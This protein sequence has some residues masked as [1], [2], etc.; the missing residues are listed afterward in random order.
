MRKFSKLTIGRAITILRSGGIGV[1]PTDTIYGII[2][3]ALDKKAV[4]RIYRLRHRHPKKPMIVLIGKVDDL[5]LFG[6]T[7]NTKLVGALE[8][9]WPGKF[10]VVFRIPRRQSLIARLHYLHRGEKSLAFRLPRPLWLR[11]LLKETGPLVAP[12]ANRQRKPAA[13][14]VREAKKIFGKNVDFYLDAGSLDS[15]P[16]TIL[17][18][19]KGKVLILRGDGNKSR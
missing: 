18:I 11:K 4:A 17:K 2:G 7:V 16:S 14:T 5:G 13:R 8:E 6:I 9:F 12:S 19:E 1:L 10:S 15:P 3:S